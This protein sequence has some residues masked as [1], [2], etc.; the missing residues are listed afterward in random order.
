MGMVLT[1]WAVTKSALEQ[2]LE[3]SERLAND[4][5]VEKRWPALDL[6]KSWQ[7]LLKV[8]NG[9]GLAGV[10]E[11]ASCL[12]LSGQ[13]I[14]EQQDLG[15]GPAHYLWPNEIEPRYCE[16]AD[17]TKGTVKLRYL[18]EHEEED[19][20]PI[21]QRHRAED[22]RCVWSYFE[23]LQVFYKGVVAQKLAIISVVN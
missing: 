4:L 3:N 16:I 6:G 7:D 11:G 19:L 8:I 21:T 2:Y 10:G 18:D 22:I 17:W 23:Q 12:L 15:C 1:I 13:L 20:T 14:D 5:Y 9:E